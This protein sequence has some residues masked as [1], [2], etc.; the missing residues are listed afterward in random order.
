MQNRRT[1]IKET[2]SLAAGL[3][4]FP[5][6]V[7][8]MEDRSKPRPFGIQLYTLRDELPGKARE[9]LQQLAKQGYTYIESY[10]GPEG[11]FWNHSAKAFKEYL[12]NLGLQIVSSHCEV[13][14]NFEKKVADAASIGIKYL[15]CPWVGPQPTIE[16]Y[17]R[18]AQ[19]FNELGSICQ[20]NG[21]RF[22]YHNHDYS[23][24]PIEGQLPQ[25]V[26]LKETDPLLVD[27]E[28]DIYWAHYAGQDPVTWFANYPNRFKL[29]HVKDKSRWPYPKEGYQSVDLGTGSIDFKKILPRAVKQGLEYLLVE[30]EFYPNGSQIEAA[31]AG[32]SYM[33]RLRF[34]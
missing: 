3:S 32:A 33:K 14:K 21:I 24:K 29:C 19:Q 6:W 20:K 9:L 15:I 2:G 1:F 16:S 30:Q 17:K 4:L 13:Q 34:G 31:A 12:D 25:E 28:L 7:Q 10:E 22:A 23:F 11:M 27:F 26:L 18:I 8:A 5:Q